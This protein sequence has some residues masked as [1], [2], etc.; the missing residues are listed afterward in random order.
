[1]LPTRFKA[2]RPYLAAHI[3]ANQERPPFAELVRYLCRPGKEIRG[4]KYI[5]RT[6][7]QGD[8]RAVTFKGFNE[9]FYYP[10]A[11]SWIDL[12]ST[13]DECFNPNNWHHYTAH[14]TP[15]NSDDVVVDC[16]AAEGLFTFI[17]AQKAR[18]VLAFEPL[19]K[20]VAALRKNFERSP[21]V[22][23]YPYALGHKAQKARITDNEILSAISSDGPIEIE[24]KTLDEI[25]L[26]S[27]EPVTFLK[28]DV[29]GGEFQLLLGAEELI[30]KYK[31]KIAVTVYHTA[32]NV[33]QM[34]TF[35]SQV[36]PSYQFATKGISENGG[37]VMLHA[38]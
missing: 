22:T 36:Q 28:A 34:Q 4:S 21:K 25:L 1:M 38:W 26:S 23:I 3:H 32:N 30:R 6:D 16:G 37:P 12:C 14:Y 20:F 31:P 24:I 8:Y 5:S 29:E 2:I 10:Q 13:I 18:K 35:L 17:C 15:V 9:P 19:P 11:C 33:P 7:E 27:G